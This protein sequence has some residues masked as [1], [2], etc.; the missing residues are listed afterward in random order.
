[1]EL[2]SGASSYDP[3]EPSDY[4]SDE[5]DVF[6]I[7]EG[8]KPPKYPFSDPSKPPSREDQ[9]AGLIAGDYRLLDLVPPAWVDAIG[10][11]T[12]DMLL[13]T[14]QGPLVAS[15]KRDTVYPD[16]IHYFR[17]LDVDPTQARV[18]ILGQ[19]PYHGPNQAHGLSFSDNSGDFAPSLNNMVKVIRANGYTCNPSRRTDGK[20]KGN[21]DHWFHQGV[22]L[23]NTGL[24]VIKGESSSHMDIGWQEVTDAIISILAS[25]GPPKVFCL[26][27]KPAQRK[28]KLI[29]SK[30]K[31]AKLKH[32]ILMTSHP[33][34]FSFHRGFHECT[35]FADANA[36]LK[37]QG[38]D[39]IDWNVC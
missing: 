31:K 21:L 11:E 26:W 27:G 13:A 24:T 22:F 19:N 5:D 10:V 14:V 6:D 28:A 29:E 9:L 3:S 32:L 12:L 4:S 2:D 37:D 15:L 25:T 8:P 18:V 16:P 20:P 1:M 36:F 17:V 33:S 30:A 39:P 7:V 23:L 35:H 34:P 38:L